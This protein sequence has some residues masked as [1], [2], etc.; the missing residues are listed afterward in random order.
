M[1]LKMNTSAKALMLMLLLKYNCDKIIAR[2]KVVTC[3]YML[4]TKLAQFI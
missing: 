4:Q 3:I 1:C 2:D